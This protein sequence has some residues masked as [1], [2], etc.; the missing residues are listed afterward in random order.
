[1]YSVNYFKGKIYSYFKFVALSQLLRKKVLVICNLRM[2]I[3]SDVDPVGSA[4]GSVDP[5]PD[6]GV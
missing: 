3:I 2:N 5:D 6:L 4:F 1:M